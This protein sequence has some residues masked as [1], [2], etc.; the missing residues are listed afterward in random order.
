MTLPTLDDLTPALDRISVDLLGDPIEY[1]ADGSAFEGAT[2]FVDYRDAS[3]AFE[4][5]QAIEQDVTVSLLKA[6]VPARPAATARLRL[7][8]LA[9]KTFKPINVRSDTSGTHWEFE[10]K[11][12]AGA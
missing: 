11:E 9:G 8:K 12:V 4:G 6:D 5:A 1:A 3:K 10:V 2:A 7:P